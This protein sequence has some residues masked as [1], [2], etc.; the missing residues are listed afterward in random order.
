MYTS[1]SLS[2]PVSTAYRKT[3]VC[4]SV[5][6]MGLVCGGC[7]WFLLSH[8]KSKDRS[9]QAASNPSDQQSAC[10]PRPKVRVGGFWISEALALSHTAQ[11]LFL[12]LC[13]NLYCSMSASE[14]AR[15][16]L[17]DAPS[18]TLAN[19][20]RRP[21]PSSF[22]LP[23]KASSICAGDA[24]RESQCGHGAGAVLEKGITISVARDPG[25]RAQV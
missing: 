20:V 11:N 22:E 10:L 18:R 8:I 21:P 25:D 3:N 1:R 7:S 5:A 15:A 4:F 12:G 2:G 17:A 14:R 19:V 13:I 24:A 9:R 6:S 16:S 23:M